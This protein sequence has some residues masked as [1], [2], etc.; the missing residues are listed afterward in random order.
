MRRDVHAVINTEAGVWPASHL[1]RRTLNELAFS[2]KLL[3]DLV[4]PN[5]QQK[6]LVDFRMAQER[7]IRSEGAVSGDRMNVGIVKTSC[8]CGT[9]TQMVP[10]MVSPVT[11]VR[12]L[13]QLGQR[14]R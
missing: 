4:L 6:L 11:R 5:I 13:W 2:D 10:A 14:K 1:L 3:E 12:F 8:R 9:G 7:A